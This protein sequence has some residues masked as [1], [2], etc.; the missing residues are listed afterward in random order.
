[1]G[2]SHATTYHGHNILVLQEGERLMAFHFHNGRYEAFSLPT[3]GLNWGS[4]G[5]TTL[6]FCEVDDLM[7]KGLNNEEPCQYG[8]TRD[9]LE[10]MGITL[11]NG[12]SNRLFNAITCTPY[13]D[14]ANPS[15]FDVEGV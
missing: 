5:H 13:I 12:E 3:L 14:R 6:G 2:S 11:D 1:M 8:W 15:I 9:R 7:R 10:Q 4:L